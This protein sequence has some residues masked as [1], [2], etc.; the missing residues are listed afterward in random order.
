MRER[1]N[2]I[3]PQLDAIRHVVVSREDLNHV[4]A[5]AKGS[6]AEILVG[7]LVEYVDQFT[8]D[9]LTLDLLAFFQEQHHA[10]V[11]FRRSQAV[12]ATHRSHNQRV[13]PFK[14][15][16]RR[17]EPQLVEFVIDGRLLFNVEI[18]GRN[19]SFGLVIVVIGNEILDGIVREETLELVI[20]LRRQRLVVRHDYRRTVHRLNY[21][22]HGE[23]LAGASNPEQN[24][25]R[26][27]VKHPA[28]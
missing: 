17:R 26:L 5:H 22:G 25:V 13:T 28:R 3:A 19:V 2:L 4:A 18:G 11:G 9:I 10:V 1:R 14:Q 20:E 16:P 8:R 21:L 27:A 7:S 12:D 15:R 24:L 6:A 23:R